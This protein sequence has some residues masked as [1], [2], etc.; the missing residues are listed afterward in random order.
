VVWGKEAS[1]SA[2]GTEQVE[3][4]EWAQRPAPSQLQKEQLG[5]WGA[6]PSVVEDGGCW[7]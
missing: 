4:Q 5:G 2:F 3:G 7:C 6:D 1:P